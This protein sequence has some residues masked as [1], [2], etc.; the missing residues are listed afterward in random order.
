VEFEQKRFRAEGNF[1]Y[2]H[3]EL[4]HE[5]TLPGGVQ[6]F[7]RVHGQLASQP[8]VNTEQVAGGGLSTVRGYLE[9]EVL[10]DNAIFGTLELRSPSLLGWIKPKGNEWRFYLFADGGTLSVRD[11]L[12]EQDAHFTLASIGVGSRLQLLDHLNG[13]VDL[14][15]PLIGQ[16]ETTPRDPR[17]SFRVWADF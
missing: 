7:G 12:P 5:Q 17:V 6:V 15:V 10:G 11:T 4:S 13:S 2:L 8:L 16:S 9:A 1:A 3:G 14:A